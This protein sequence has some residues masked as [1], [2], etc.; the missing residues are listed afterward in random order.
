MYREL[1]TAKRRH[2]RRDS[3]RNT[4]SS[5]ASRHLIREEGP[6]ATAVEERNKHSTK[7]RIINSSSN[8][9]NL[10]SH[11]K[12]IA[13]KESLYRRLVLN[14]LKNKGTRTTSKTP[15]QTNRGKR[16]ERIAK[17]QQQQEKIAQRRIARRPV[18]SISGSNFTPGEKDS[19]NCAV[20][21][22]LFGF[23]QNKMPKEIISLLIRQ[24]DQEQEEEIYRTQH[25]H[26]FDLAKTWMTEDSDV[27]NSHTD[28]RKVQVHIGQQLVKVAT[29]SRRRKSNK[30]EAFVTKILVRTTKRLAEAAA[31]E[32]NVT[33]LQV[34]CIQGLPPNIVAVLIDEDLSPKQQLQH[35]CSS[36]VNQRNDMG[37]IPLHSIVQCICE[38]GIPYSEGAE[39]I[40][41]LC[42]KDIHTIHSS[43]FDAT[44]P[45]DL[46][47]IALVRKEKMIRQR[48]RNRNTTV[49]NK[50][51]TINV[52][53]MNLRRISISSYRLYKMKCEQDH[54]DTKERLE[55]QLLENQHEWNIPLMG[56]GIGGG[57]AT[58]TGTSSPMI[59][60]AT[61]IRNTT[62]WPLSQG[63]VG[64]PTRS[65]THS[66][67]RTSYFNTRPG[68]SANLDVNERNLD[69]FNDCPILETAHAMKYSCR[70]ASYVEWRNGQ[71]Y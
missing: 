42:A 1:A 37:R 9:R 45:T 54:F 36:P 15:S 23:Q 46:A 20:H 4:S 55:E 6:T 65:E 3:I 52:L 30:N 66:S 11:D 43:D 44:S 24:S 59:A 61:A 40:D 16:S 47:H 63:V 17:R 56:I 48:A 38:G 35:G 8:P 71:M 58:G 27:L 51:Q 19:L 14:K 70:L 57:I 41:L 10:N 31:V 2:K 62:S 26:F 33:P 21:W 29:K 18:S 69:V 25:E 64:A 49:D 39:I 53:L 67:L 60:T 5:A 32:M 28:H 22:K 12:D 13:Q 7:D 50:I 34:A 68:S